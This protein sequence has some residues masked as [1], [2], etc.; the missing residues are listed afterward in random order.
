MLPSPTT[1]LDPVLLDTL[2]LPLPSLPDLPRVLARGLLMLMPTMDTPPM[3]MLPTTGLDPA[4]LDTPPEL[5][6]LPDLPRD[7]A[8]GLLML[9]LMPTMDTPMLTD[10]DIPM[11]MDTD[12]MDT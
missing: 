6:L 9:M 11:L 5:P 2:E 4:L 10:M 8:R 1:E 3:A 12:L 7:L